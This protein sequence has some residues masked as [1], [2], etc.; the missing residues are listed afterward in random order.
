MGPGAGSSEGSFFHVGWDG[1]DYWALEGHL[2]VSPR[3][4]PHSVLVSR[5]VDCTCVAASSQSQFQRA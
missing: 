2:P 1:Y 3:G 4:L 5:S